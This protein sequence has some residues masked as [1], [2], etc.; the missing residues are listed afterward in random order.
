MIVVEKQFSYKQQIE[1][2]LKQL[3]EERRFFYSKWISIGGPMF[4]EDYFADNIYVST[5]GKDSDITLWTLLEDEDRAIELAE[6]LD[7]ELAKQGFVCK[8]KV[9][10]CDSMDDTGVRKNFDNEDAVNKALKNNKLNRGSR[11]LTNILNQQS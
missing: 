9:F 6:F 3:H 11:F 8:I 10:L 4:G 2:L 7:A 1:P 5:R